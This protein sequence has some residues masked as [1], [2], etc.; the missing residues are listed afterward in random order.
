MTLARI[1]KGTDRANGRVTERPSHPSSL[2][3]VMIGDA[4]CLFIARASYTRG[5][6]DARS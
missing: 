4:G 2:R 5:T 3:T 6:S 1:N